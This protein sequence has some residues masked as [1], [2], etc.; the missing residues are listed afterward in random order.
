M[1]DTLNF[2]SPTT[3]D[4]DKKAAYES[5]E[6][7]NIH[8]YQTLIDDM[9][10]AKSAS[11]IAKD[12]AYINGFDKKAF[13]KYNAFVGLVASKTSSISIISHIACFSF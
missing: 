9:F 6:R 12:L 2:N 3:T 8:D 13:E 1:S 7:A 10:K 4:N 11:V 5:Y